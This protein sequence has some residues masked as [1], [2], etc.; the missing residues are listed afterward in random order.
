MHED[1]VRLG[2]LDCGVA[3]HHFFC[4]RAQFGQIVP[5]IEPEHFGAVRERMAFP[6]HHAELL[7]GPIEPGLALGAGIGHARR[8]AV[9][10]RLRIAIF[11]DDAVGFHDG[12]QVLGARAS[13]GRERRKR[14]QRQ[15]ECGAPRICRSSYRMR[16]FHDLSPF[17]FCIRYI[18]ASESWLTSGIG[19]AP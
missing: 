9:E 2:I 18:D 6:D 19:A 17:K 7:A 1:A 14:C 8:Y 3:H 16:L 13:A 5:T 10:G 4:Q 12:L 11:H 15:P